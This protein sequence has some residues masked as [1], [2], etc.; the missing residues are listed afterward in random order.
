MTNLGVHLSIGALVGLLL[1]GDP[2]S[3]LGHQVRLSPDDRRTLDRGGTVAR[4]LA[5]GK[6][7]VA[8]LAVSEIAAAPQVLVDAARSI[9]ELKRSSF[10]TAVKTF[11]DPPRL[12]DLDGLVL[13]PRDVQAAMRCTPGNCSFKF[14]A[15]EI[16]V[17]VRD[18]DAAAPADQVGAIQR[19]FRRIVFERVTTYLAGGLAALPPVANRGAPFCLDR[20]FTEIVSDAPTLPHVPQAGAFPRDF[21]AAGDRIESFV[22]WSYENYGPGKPM[23]LVTH[24]GIIAPAAP[25]EPAIVLGKQILATRYMTGGLSIT[26]VTTDAGTG[27]HYLVYLNRTGVDLLGGL[28]GPV[29]RAVLESRLRSEVPEII[30][31]LR[32]RLERSAALPTAR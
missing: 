5:G 30:V 21:P 28:F 15:A 4:T 1:A 17:L 25:G 7:Q 19:A 20:V 27:R 16:A 3:F 10:V 13:A 12:E 22:Y 32:E 14:S 6:D 9:E 11:S 8:V 26:A 24:V 18:R 23:V 29:K 2:F 31:K